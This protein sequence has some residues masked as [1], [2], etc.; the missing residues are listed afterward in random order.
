MTKPVE[1]KYDPLLV[2][3]VQ[4]L[5]MKTKAAHC[6]IIDKDT[7]RLSVKDQIGILGTICMEAPFIFVPDY[8][9]LHLMDKGHCCGL[10]SDMITVY[11]TGRMQDNDSQ[12][13]Q[14]K[15]E[16]TEHIDKIKQERSKNGLDCN[17]CNV[18]WCSQQCKN[19]D[20]S[21][22]LLNHKPVNKSGTKNFVNVD[23]TKKQ[24]FSWQ[25]W[26][27]LRENINSPLTFGVARVIMHL[28]YDESLMDTYA[29]MRCFISND[30]DVFEN[31]L[32]IGYIDQLIDW[33]KFYQL[34]VGCLKGL[35]IDYMSFLRYAS[36]YKLN[37][38]NGSIYL[39]F[40]MIDRVEGTNNI[41][42][43]IYDDK[44]NQEY[45][46]IEGKNSGHI[47]LFHF[48][49]TAKRKPFF[50]NKSSCQLSK[51]IL[52]FR[53][54]TEL[55]PNDKLTIKDGDYSSADD[56]ELDKCVLI[57]DNAIF[58]RSDIPIIE[59]NEHVADLA[60]TAPTPI[61]AQRRTSLTSS[62]SSF[63]QGIYKFPVQA[64]RESILHGP[65]STDGY[66][67]A[68]DSHDDDSIVD[69]IVAMKEQQ[70]PDRRKSVRFQEEVR[71]DESETSH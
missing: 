58:L 22:D 20:F 3:V 59:V 16:K 68:I 1:I 27:S 9:K 24:V 41:T 63:G 42:V 71:E 32:N 44:A 51:A 56:T 70:R 43:H 53:S 38:Y 45:D 2:P 21:H 39:L 14:V 31:F 66:E 62:R 5:L 36:I 34:L 52:Q 23:G 69:V 18:K 29:K 50:T 4:K 10:C 47:S 30:E 67:S 46:K 65:L 60:I 64:F 13:K 40:S 11:N 19:L 57:K 15:K 37:N 48:D 7:N 17:E 26:D 49:S 12:T 25:H 54:D 6:L 28:F 8:S 33:K 61:T 55:M 35:A